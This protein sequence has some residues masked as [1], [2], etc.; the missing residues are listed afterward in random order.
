MSFPQKYFIKQY[1]KTKMENVDIMC[2]A[3]KK[4]FTWTIDRTKLEE[5]QREERPMGP[6]I[7]YSVSHPIQCPNCGTFLDVSIFEYPENQFEA[8]VIETN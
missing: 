2:P 6:R 4:T 3:C 7:D 1:K 8:T 5:N